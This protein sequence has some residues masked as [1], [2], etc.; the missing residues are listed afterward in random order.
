MTYKSFKSFILEF[1]PGDEKVHDAIN[2][3]KDLSSKTNH[4]ATMNKERTAAMVQANKDKLA[5]T[6]SR[7]FTRKQ[8]HDD[9]VSRAVAALKKK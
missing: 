3:A 9:Q 6:R 8:R 4:I 2:R 7:E 5:A 1:I